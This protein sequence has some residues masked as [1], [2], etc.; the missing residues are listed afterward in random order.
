[1]WSVAEFVHWARIRQAA[2]CGTC[3]FDPI[4]YQKNWKAARARVE[5]RL[6]TLE[7]NQ[8]AKLREEMSRS[9]KSAGSASP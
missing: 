1:V 6:K 2:K 8:I 3:D 9:Q 7:Q 4:L 5:N